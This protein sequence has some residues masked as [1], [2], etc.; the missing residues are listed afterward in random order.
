MK[1]SKFLDSQ[2]IEA[3]KR[4]ESRFFGSLR[5]RTRDAYSKYQLCKCALNQQTMTNGEIYKPPFIVSAR[6]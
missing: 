4:V 5:A 6:S 2:I 1:R 3:I